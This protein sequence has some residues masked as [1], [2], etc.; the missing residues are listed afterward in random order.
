MNDD[1]LIDGYFH[2]QLSPDEVQKLETRLKN[3]AGVRERFRRYGEM[4]YGL[5]TTSRL[6]DAEEQYLRAGRELPKPR[7]FRAPWAQVAAACVFT[8]ILSSSAAAWYVE[9]QVRQSEHKTILENDFESP[10]VEVR[11]R[12]PVPLGVWHGDGVPTTWE[13]G[14][15]KPYSG[16][17]Y[18]RLLPH[19][20]R[21]LSYLDGVIDLRSVEQMRQEKGAKRV[22]LYCRA[23]VRPEAITEIP[24]SR[25][26][27][28]LATF[29]SPPEGTADEWRQGPPQEYG[30]TFSHRFIKVKQGL[31]QWHILETTVDVPADVQSAM[32]S[33]SAGSDN[34]TTTHCVDSI[35]VEL[36]FEY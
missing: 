14:L 18:I 19:E 23:F 8:A 11:K 12:F 17:R 36:V 1:E 13:E 35:Q 27:L 6:G 33:V 3:D 10:E 5:E 26:R 30:V 24:A 2:D 21:A 15:P 16:S 32:L 20:K 28:R 22:R 31:D 25:Y 34:A 4:V 7:P 9:R 29:A